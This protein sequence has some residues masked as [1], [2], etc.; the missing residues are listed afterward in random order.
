MSR[1]GRRDRLRFGNGLSLAP[2]D[3]RLA[4]A[5]LTPRIWRLLEDEGLDDTVRQLVRWTDPDTPELAGEDHEAN[6]EKIAGSL[7]RLWWRTL[8][9]C[10]GL[11]LMA[12]P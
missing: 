2:T 9:A 4:I 11:L 1:S 12:P 7:Y 5:E 8:P 10:S 6:F 3:F